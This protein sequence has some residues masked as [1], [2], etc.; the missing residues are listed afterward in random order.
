M[1]ISAA[2]LQQLCALIQ[3]GRGELFY[4]W[5]EW[6]ALRAEVLRLDNR[7]CQLC[8]AKGRHSPAR[9]VHHVKHLRERPDLALSLFDGDVRQLISVCKRCH[10]LLH[11][12]GQRQSQISAKPLT[13]ERWD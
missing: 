2:R 13:P 7:E 12:E 6:Q 4:H 9:I 3:A 10:E 1:A 11:P 5:P 8:K